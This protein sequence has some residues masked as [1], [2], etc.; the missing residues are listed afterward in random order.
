MRRIPSCCGI[1]RYSADTSIVSRM[2]FWGSVVFSMMLMKSLVSLM[3][4][5]MLVRVFLRM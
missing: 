3:Y 4:D 5:G 2:Q 1:L